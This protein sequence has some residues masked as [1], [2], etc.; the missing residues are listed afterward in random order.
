[1]INNLEQW[2]KWE[3]IPNLEEQYELVDYSNNIQDG[4]NL[5]FKNNNKKLEI[6][7]KHS[8]EIRISNK[9]LRD[10]ELKNLYQKN[11][12]IFMNWSFFKVNNS[13]YLKWLSVESLT[14]TDNINFT[15]FCIISYQVIIDIIAGYEPKV[16]LHL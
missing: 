14:V 10:K 7:F 4:F 3:P 13:E 9:N 15:H 11:G 6:L 8:A 1:M 12:K 5:I 16:Q 2:I